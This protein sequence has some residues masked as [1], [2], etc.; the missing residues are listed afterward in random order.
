VKT[1]ARRSVAFGTAGAAG[2]VAL[3]ALVLPALASTV[4]PT[5]LGSALLT[6]AIALLTITAQRSRDRHKQRSELEGALRTWPPA[7]LAGADVKTLG[8]FPGGGSDGRPDSYESRRGD[9]VLRDALEHDDLVVVHGPPAAGKSRAAAE[10]ARQV[11]PDVPAVIPMNADALA[12]LADGTL[13]STDL[14][15]QRVVLWLDGLER[16]IDA[17]DAQVL[18][19]LAGL[20]EQVKIVSTIRTDKWEELLSGGGPTGEAARAVADAA[21]VVD[22]GPRDSGDE[23]TTPETPSSGSVVESGYSVPPMWGDGWLLAYAAGLLAT[24]I[25]VLVVGLTGLGGGLI[26]PP[27]IADQMSSIIDGLTRQAGAGGGRVVLDERVPFHAS[28]AD[29]WVLGIED[30][31][32][33]DRFTNAVANCSPQSP[34]NCENPPPRSDE[35]RIYDVSGGRLTLQLDYR[36]AGTGTQAAALDTVAG[37]SS[38]GGDYDHDAAP[39]LIAA[40]SYPDG[41]NVEL[42]FGVYWRDG[43]YK[44]VSLTTTHPPF[45]THGLDPHLTLFTKQAYEQKMSLRNAVSD[46]RF[47][48]LSLF[49]FTVQT[50][51]L[52]QTPSARL[53]TGYY[54]AYPGD[55]RQTKR[56]QLEA[57]QIRPGLA[58]IHQGGRSKRWIGRKLTRAGCRD[59]G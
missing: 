4:K 35:L 33:H 11:L 14:P 26:T 39:E 52:I 19:R 17:I 50:V 30:N 13:C 8:V 56:L 55:Y 59:R 53:L 10:A 18:G 27:P 41:A 34:A 7:S 49:G 54:S 28:E 12:S 5:T 21:R 22:I 37:T 2:G 3:T 36:P 24:L 20:A 16:F 38:S 44:L 48:G 9:A 46:P 31:P 6:V 25:A 51:A 43:A 58:R 57:S 23:K 47:S 42:P 45:P 40:Y 29:S 1:A 32:S 15:G